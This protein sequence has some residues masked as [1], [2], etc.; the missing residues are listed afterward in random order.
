[1][2]DEK[3][4][5]SESQNVQEDNRMKTKCKNQRAKKLRKVR[6]MVERKE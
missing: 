5:Y 4:S 6:E 1:M 2:K 3:K